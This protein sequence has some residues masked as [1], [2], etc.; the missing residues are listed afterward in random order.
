[1][2][3]SR[4]IVGPAD[5]FDCSLKI[6]SRCRSFAMFSLNVTAFPAA[7]VIEV[8]DFSLRFDWLVLR[9]KFYSGASRC[10]DALKA[11]MLISVI[12]LFLN[13][14]VICLGGYF[15]NRFAYLTL[16]LII[17]RF[18]WKVLT[19]RSLCSDPCLIRRWCS[20]RANQTQCAYRLCHHRVYLLH[21]ASIWVCCLEEAR[22]L[23]LCSRPTMSHVKRRK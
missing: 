17:E 21:A 8:S 23:F 2:V 13:S 14:W 5:L 6:S 1:M 20:S 10:F 12:K 3:E 15:I 9:P 7:W 19:T 16:T 11:K 4:E 18:R 22:R